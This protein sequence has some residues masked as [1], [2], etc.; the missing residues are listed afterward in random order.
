MLVNYGLIVNNYNSFG[1]LVPLLMLFSI[2]YFL[3]Q[4]TLPRAGFRGEYSKSSKDFGKTLG[5]IIL[6]YH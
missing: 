6:K 3:Y 4:K 5:K 2:K 1:A